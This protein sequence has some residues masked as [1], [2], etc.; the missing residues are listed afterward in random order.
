[1][2]EEDQGNGLS[3][4]DASHQALRA[5]QR[6]LGL[7]DENRPDID[8]RLPSRAQ[9]D[10]ARAGIAPTLSYGTPPGIDHPMQRLP[11]VFPRAGN[12][13]RATQAL[14]DRQRELGLRDDN[15]P[16]MARNA[17]DL[18]EVYNRRRTRGDRASAP[19]RPIRSDKQKPLTEPCYVRYDPFPDPEQVVFCNEWVR[20]FI[21]SV[22]RIGVQKSVGEM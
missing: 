18:A 21:T 4:A 14:H 13:Y 19:D 2:H 11:P 3:V 20:I 15:G 9:L 22:L 12:D 7:M 6:R 8:D 10:E 5:A 17:H 16:V 1:M